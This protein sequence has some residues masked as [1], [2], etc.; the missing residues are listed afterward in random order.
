MVQK[1]KNQGP[2]PTTNPNQLRVTWSHH[3]KPGITMVHPEP[4]LQELKR[5]TEIRAQ[6]PK[7]LDC[8]SPTRIGVEDVTKAVAQKTTQNG[9]L[10]SGKDQNLQFP[11]AVPI[12]SHRKPAVCPSCCILRTP[13]K[14]K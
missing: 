2:N 13:N 14:V 6:W 5:Q 1:P 3:Q 7:R 10:V 4:V 11:P 12:F 9:T 8:R